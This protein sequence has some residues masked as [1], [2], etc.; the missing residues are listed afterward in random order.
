MTQSAEQLSGSAAALQDTVEI[1]ARRGPLT[2]PWGKLQPGPR[3]RV[4][5]LRSQRQD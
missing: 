2:P 5:R 3:S 4:R 1:P